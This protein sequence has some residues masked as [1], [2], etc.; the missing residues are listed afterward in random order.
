[1]GS[2][3]TVAATV[4]LAVAVAVGE[5]VAVLRT[6][7]PSE[8]KNAF[9]DGRCTADRFEAVPPEVL[10]MLKRFRLRYTEPPRFLARGLKSPAPII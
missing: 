1:V 2:G 8:V 4:G 3:L 7:V 5:L 6:V 9:G 10:H